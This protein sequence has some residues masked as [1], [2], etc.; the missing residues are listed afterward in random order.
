MTKEEERTVLRWLR[1]RENPYDQNC[2]LERRILQ[3]ALLNFEPISREIRDAM[4]DWIETS[5]ATLFPPKPAPAS[6]AH[7]QSPPERRA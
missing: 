7:P 5:P 2:K 1:G 4:A 3:R 6:L